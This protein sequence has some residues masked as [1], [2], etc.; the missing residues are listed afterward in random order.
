MIPDVAGWC[1]CRHCSGP[2]Q[3]RSGA[4]PPVVL[5]RWV[6]TPRSHRRARAAHPRFRLHR[7]RPAGGH[8]LG[9][10]AAVRVYRAGAAD[11]SVRLAAA[12]RHPRRNHRAGKPQQNG[13]LER[14]H[15]TLKAEM[16]SPPASDLRSQFTSIISIAASLSSD[17]AAA[18]RARPRC[19]SSDP[20]CGRR[21]A[22]YI[23][24]RRHST[25]E[26]DAGESLATSTMYVSRHTPVSWIC[27]C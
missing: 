4:G 7:V 13:R 27:G 10:W 18:R 1:R 14:F 2:L 11:R 9:R 8:P 15:R 12:A 3:P 23:A 5:A 17:A 19:R 20:A 25:D 22:R 21:A 26:R 6:Q 24:L 16:A